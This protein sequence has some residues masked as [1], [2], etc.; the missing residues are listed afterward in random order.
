M[1][2]PSGCPDQ[3]SGSARSSK[4]REQLSRSPRKRREGKRSQRRGD[5]HEQRLWEMERRRWLS[6]C[7]SKRGVILTPPFSIFFLTGEL[8]FYMDR[9]QP[10]TLDPKPAFSPTQLQSCK[11]EAVKKADLC[12]H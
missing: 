10:L 3:Q 11:H 2:R 1:L 8:T 4:H 7:C 5:D 9:I 6:F 12:V